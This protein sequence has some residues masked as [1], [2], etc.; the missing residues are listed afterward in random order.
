VPGGARVGVLTSLG[1]SEFEDVSPDDVAVPL[2]RGY[3][4]LVSEHRAEQV[5]SHRWR[6]SVRAE[7]VA[8]AITTTR[9][10]DGRRHT[11]YLHR[12][13]A[14][15]RW[16]WVEVDH[17]NR[18][19]L[20]CRDWNLRVVPHGTNVANRMPRDNRWGYTGVYQR[21]SGRFGVRAMLFEE[22]HH[23]GTYDTPEEAGRA[24]DAFVLEHYGEFAMTNARRL[25]LVNPGSRIVA[26]RA[27][28]PA[29]I[30]F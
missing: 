22:V 10:D 3:Y 2:T 20:D 18:N 8:Y 23:L 21:P 14:R 16:G 27:E 30:P 25:G 15:P 12:H 19:G 28:E 29:E 9:G 5:L 24:Y 6:V 26:A 4:A 13:V 7:G 17:L 1:E 11:V